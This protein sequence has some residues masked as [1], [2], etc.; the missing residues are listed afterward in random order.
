MELTATV[1][2]LSSPALRV[3]RKALPCML[4]LLGLLPLLFLKEQ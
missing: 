4:C 3:S 2:K 1:G